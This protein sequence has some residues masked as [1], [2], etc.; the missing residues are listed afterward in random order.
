MPTR[1]S[2]GRIVAIVGLVAGGVVG[3]GCGGRGNPLAPS[4]APVLAGAASV[5]PP[6]TSAAGASIVGLVARASVA[7]NIETR[8]VGLSVS[9][10]G[11]S[12]TAP[13][14]ERGRFELR[15]VP[16]GDVEL[17]FRGA[18]IDASLRL[19]DVRDAESIDLGVNLS[20]SAAVVTNLSRQG[21]DAVRLVG[22]IESVDVVARTF[23]VSGRTVIV[24]STTSIVRSG[25]VRTFDTLAAGAAVKVEGAVRPEAVLA[26]KVELEDGVGPT[27]TP[28]PTP[29]PIPTPTPAPGPA[30]VP[31]PVSTEVTIRGTVSGVG[32]GCPA[33]TFSVGTTTVRTT[34][35]TAFVKVQCSD[36]RSGVVVEAEG[37]R[38]TA[39][40]LVAKK[41]QAEDRP[42]TSQPP[43][44]QEVEFAGALASLGGVA[45]VLTL[46]VGGRSVRTS[47]ATV[48]RRRGDP[49]DFSL[50]KPGQTVEVK[51]TLGSD[52]VVAAARITI[53][54][55]VPIAPAPS[56]NPAPMPVGQEV[57]F[58]GTIGAVTGLGPGLSL[59]VAG[60][61][62]VTTSSTEV[63]RKGN[64]VSADSLKAGIR[65][66]VKGAR[67]ADGSVV[68]KRITIED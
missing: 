64:A 31:P 43:A 19:D 12:S 57:E 52:G 37:S 7:Q 16:P 17:R 36:L 49:V 65:V 30:P 32:S 59:T 39:G 61:T 26:T 46:Q 20:P 33:I 48:V 6:T 56:P 28:I 41:V 24:T 62:V 11:T 34:N 14:D 38:D 8:E 35:A 4:S 27:P 54:S 21:E 25:Q 47:A 1:M 67:Q 44:V 60:R 63:R 53:E 3:V 5:A 23:R 13:V 9:V 45:P 22:T 18:G 50:L 29:A 51:G 66:E 2:V 40:V 55:D 15:Q 42:A 10:T 68:A 58:T